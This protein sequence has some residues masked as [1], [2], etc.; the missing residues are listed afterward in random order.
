MPAK[1]G[2]AADLTLFWPRGLNAVSAAA[3][4]WPKRHHFCLIYLFSP[5]LCQALRLGEGAGWEVSCPTAASHLLQP[6]LFLFPLSV[7]AEQEPVRG[8][9]LSL[10]SGAKTIK[11]TLVL[12]Q[13]VPQCV[14]G[15]L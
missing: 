3:L 1:P 11:T 10:R 12:Y 4:S 13:H 14:G 5:G 8:C 7:L 6:F 15:K 2:L 9:A